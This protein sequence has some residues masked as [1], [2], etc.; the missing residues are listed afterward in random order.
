MALHVF[1]SSTYP[2]DRATYR[3]MVRHGWIDPTADYDEAAQAVVASSEGDP[4][5]LVR[6]SLGF[7]D[8]GRRYCKAS[9]PRCGP[10]PLKSTLPDG[11]PIAT[12]G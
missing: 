10:C 5:A 7:A 12:D 1:A 6:F 8:V 11:G 9:A 2:V 3:I 4:S